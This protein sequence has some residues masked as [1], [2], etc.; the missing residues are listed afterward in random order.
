M[1]SGVLCVINGAHHWAQML[2]KS[3]SFGQKRE[4]DKYIELLNGM[5]NHEFMERKTVT[6]L[7]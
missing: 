1:L 3:N 7:Q 6:M 5:F 4:P 2:A